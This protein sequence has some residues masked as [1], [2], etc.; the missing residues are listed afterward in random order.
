MSLSLPLLRAQKKSL[1]A[2]MDSLS[3]Q[4]SATGTSLDNVNRQI[5]TVTNTTSH[6]YS[7]PNEIITLVFES[8]FQTSQTFPILVSHISHRLREVALCSPTLWTRIFVSLGADIEKVEAY[9][10]RSK[11]CLLEMTVSA[12]MPRLG[13][14]SSHYAHLRIILSHINRWHSLDISGAWADKVLQELGQLSASSLERLFLRAEG[15][16]LDWT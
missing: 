5:A 14:T 9:L 12:D 8:G 4:L 13:S 15:I 1:E 7:L 6:I 16:S 10:H 2:E 3:Q 11:G